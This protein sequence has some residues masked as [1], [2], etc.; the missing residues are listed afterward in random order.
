MP[1]K[2]NQQQAEKAFTAR[3][4]S[5]SSAERVVSAPLVT[6][7]FPQ[8]TAGAEGTWQGHGSTSAGDTGVHHIAELPKPAAR[9]DTGQDR[10][11]PNPPI[12]LHEKRVNHPERVRQATNTSRT[13]VCPAKSPG[14][15][16][17]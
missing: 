4:P 9:P 3:N 14:K 1:N 15:A 11:H 2:E 10:S 12:S 6:Q 5:S 16:F 13:K 17:T 7:G 8:E